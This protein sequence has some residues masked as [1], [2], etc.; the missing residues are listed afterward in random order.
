MSTNQDCG[1][2]T[3]VKSCLANC[4]IMRLKICQR[5]AS[6]APKFPSSVCLVLLHYNWISFFPSG[7][8]FSP[9][10]ILVY[11]IVEFSCEKTDLLFKKTNHINQFHTK[12]N[13]SYTKF[14][15]FKTFLNCL[16]HC[17]TQPTT[18][19]AETL[20]NAISTFST[21]V[22]LLKIPIVFRVYFSKF[23][24]KSIYHIFN[25]IYFW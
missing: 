16:K 9:L 3:N 6:H 12:I 13:H 5:L 1:F 21:M 24:F 15:F 22:F 17:L 8:L 14:S 23:H 18:I 11:L 7:P 19:F 10:I 25:E 4:A 2:L 20:F